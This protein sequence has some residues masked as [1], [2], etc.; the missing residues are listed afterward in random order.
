MTI[1]YLG[2]NQNRS[3]GTAQLSALLFL[4]PATF[5]IQA[6]LTTMLQRLDPD[7]L[8]GAVPRHVPSSPFVILVL[9]ARRNISIEKNQGASILCS[10][11]REYGGLRIYKRDS[12]RAAVSVSGPQQ[13]STLFDPNTLFSFEAACPSNVR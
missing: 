12:L 10:P 7:V 3:Y 2:G 13:W 11:L 6:A 9:Q 8:R 5:V 4:S 1:T